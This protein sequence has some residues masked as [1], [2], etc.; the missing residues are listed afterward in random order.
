MGFE[1]LVRKVQETHKTEGF[2][3][4]RALIPDEM[5]DVVPMYAGSDLAGLPARLREYADAGST[6]CV[7]AYVPSGD[8]LWGELQNYLNLADFARAP[9]LQ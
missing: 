5:F 1:P 2:A 8:D 3:A 7:V 9:A 4:A 6:R